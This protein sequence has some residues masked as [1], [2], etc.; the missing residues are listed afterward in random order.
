MILLD[1]NVF[2]YLANGTIAAK[3]L[4]KD[5]I[6]FASI[7]KIEAL[8]YAQITVAEHSYLDALFA[9]C[10]QLNLSEAVI[11][12]SIRLRQQTK[13]SLGDAVIT[14]T[15]LEQDCELWTANEGDFAHIEG[16]RLH[17]P[18]AK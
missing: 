18:I 10:E 7:T 8:G 11:Q 3:V 13:M 1:T 6:A 17:N 2:I 9:E 4:K 14:A 5:D 16:L 15:A 12:R